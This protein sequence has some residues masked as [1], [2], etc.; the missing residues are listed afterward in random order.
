MI[1][2]KIVVDKVSIKEKINHK[3]RVTPRDNQIEVAIP[4]MGGVP[5]EARA[6]HRAEQK[7]TTG[8]LFPLFY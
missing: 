6:L 8:S 3:S 1:E 5:N 7:E 4:N 2:S